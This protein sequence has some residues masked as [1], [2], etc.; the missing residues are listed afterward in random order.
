MHAADGEQAAL[1][2]GP[3]GRAWVEAQEL[4][5]RVF[6]PFEDMLVKAIGAGSGGRA[7]DVGCGTGST[8]LGVARRLGP[9]GRCTGIDISASM[10]TAARVRAERERTSAAFVCADAQG[11]PFAPGGYDFVVSRF[12]V[13]F[14]ED[15]VRAFANL[16]RA[17]AENAALRFVAWRSAAENP[18]MT[19]AERS[20]APLLPTLAARR[21]DSPGQFAFADGDRVQAILEASGWIGIDIQAVDVPC[22]LPEKDLVHYLTRLGPVGRVLEELDDCA[23]ARVIESV[24]PAFDSYV[25]GGEVHFTAACWAVGARASSIPTAPPFSARNDVTSTAIDRSAE[26]AENRGASRGPGVTCPL[27]QRLSGRREDDPLSS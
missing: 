10:I 27:A 23:R 12:G 4:L 26:G 16:R 8:T 1:W 7:L 2:N 20:A 24:R 11:Y 22:V 19:T 14:F 13:M 25:K 9:E 15:P 21:P 3:A 5:D 6:A 17:A 18:F